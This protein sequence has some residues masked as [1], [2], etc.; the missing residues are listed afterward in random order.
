MC[1]KSNHIPRINDIE[2]TP[3]LSKSLLIK[4]FDKDIDE[5]FIGSHMGN[6]NVSLDDM[7]SQ[8][9]VPDINV[10]DSR[11]L[12]RVVSNLYGTLIVT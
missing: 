11:M 4:G 7:I 6:L 3:Y 9:V 8:K 10:F 12:I 2:F 1:N 5:L